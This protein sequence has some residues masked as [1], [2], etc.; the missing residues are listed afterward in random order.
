ML[1]TGQP[2]PG[3]QFGDSVLGQLDSGQTGTFRIGIAAIV[4][5]LVAVVTTSVS[6]TSE[7]SKDA[8]AQSDAS[9]VNSAAASYFA[10]QGGAE[11]LTP[12]TQTV[13]AVTADIVQTSS[14]SWPEDHLTT[15]Y[16]SVLPGD[17]IITVTDILFL[18]DKG[19][20]LVTVDPETNAASDFVVDDLLTHY[21]AVD[22]D[23]LINDA[24]MVEPPNSAEQTGQTFADYLWLLEKTNVSGS[25]TDD[26]SRNVVVF[27]LI[28]VT[29]LNPGVDDTV[30]LLYQQIV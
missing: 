13:L 27:K 8:Q 30:V 24:Y 2:D 11:S 3:I 29:A 23:A 21:T 12:I 28:S 10:D 25:L 22:F 20:T 26:V 19:D 7:T 17:A 16:A 9:T 6:G 5:V 1:I 14:S 18:D 4:A 15:V